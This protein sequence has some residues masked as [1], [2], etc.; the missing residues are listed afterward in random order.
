M[1]LEYEPSSAGCQR[2]KGNESAGNNAGNNS[3][4]S[5]LAVYTFGCNSTEQ[6]FQVQGYLEPYTLY[7]YPTPYTLY[8]IPYTLYPIP[9]TL[10]PIQGYAETRNLTICGVSAGDVPRVRVQAAGM[11]C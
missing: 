8:P 11:L 5:A 3:N 10:Y 9:C 2:G 7:L 4:A 1:S 6:A